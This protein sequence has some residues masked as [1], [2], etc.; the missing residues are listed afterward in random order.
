M[1]EI[2]KILLTILAVI[3]AVI[4]ALCIAGW[5]MK[6]ACDFIIRDLKEKKALDPASAVELPYAKS[7]L[8]NIGLRDYRPRALEELVKQDIVRLLEG[9]RYYLREGHKLRATDGGTA[10]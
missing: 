3:G 8:I 1:P 7:P 5:K 10:G 4:L 6:K 2:L 9:R